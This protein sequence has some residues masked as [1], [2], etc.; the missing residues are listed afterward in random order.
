MFDR[1]QQNSVKQLSFKWKKKNKPKIKPTKQTKSLFH[2]LSASGQA[3]LEA[4]AEQGQGGECMAKALKFSSQED[5]STMAAI[6]QGGL[7]Y[8][9][10]HQEIN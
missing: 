1:K 5:L 10:S 6:D 2:L 9:L 7:I 4:G 3:L 8:G